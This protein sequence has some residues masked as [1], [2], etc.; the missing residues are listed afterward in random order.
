MPEI[1]VQQDVPFRAPPRRHQEDICVLQTE[2][3]AGMQARL[4]DDSNGMLPRADLIYT[5]THTQM[6]TRR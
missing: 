5:H 3:A 2:T 6:H 1:T 4:R